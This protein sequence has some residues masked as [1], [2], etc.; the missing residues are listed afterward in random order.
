[1]D[2]HDMKLFKLSTEEMSNVKVTEV[3]G[4]DVSDTDTDSD[5]FQIVQRDLLQEV[6]HLK[7]YQL[8]N[9]EV[10]EMT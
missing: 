10:F 5:K 6:T 8:A 7:L 2:G 3:E 4:V 9:R 1:M